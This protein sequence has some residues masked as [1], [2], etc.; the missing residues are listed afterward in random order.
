MEPKVPRSVVGKR[1]TQESLWVAPVWVQRPEDQRVMVKVSGRTLAC[2]RPK[3]RQ[4][5]YSSPKT[6]KQQCPRSTVRQEFPLTCLPFFFFLI[7]VF[8]PPNE[9]HP[10]QVGQATLLSLVF[11]ML[12]QKCLHKVLR[13]MFDQMS[14]HLGAQSVWHM[15]SAITPL[16]QVLSCSEELSLSMA[17]KPSERRV[18]VWVWTS[19]TPVWSLQ[20]LSK[21]PEWD[22]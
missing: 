14:R 17:L 22:F 7:Q 15:K 2:L 8:N 20:L 18:L 19:W 9:A 1:D 3:K 5:F 21:N 16:K 11:Q 13:I 6:R 10:R 4:C 12:L